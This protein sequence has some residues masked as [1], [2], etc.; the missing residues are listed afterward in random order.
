MIK[1][2]FSIETLL[3]VLA[4]VFSM[5]PLLKRLTMGRF[6]DDLMYKM[7]SED[8]CKYLADPARYGKVVGL[9]VIVFLIVAALSIVLLVIAN[10]IR[11]HIINI[12]LIVLIV[13]INM[14][15]AL[16]IPHHY[17]RIYPDGY[18]LCDH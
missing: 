6:I 13:L 15:S 3:R 17:Y 7:Y 14:F 16:Y 10:R 9:C 4:L 18:Q 11:P 8:A 1:K 12:V 5:I 2:I